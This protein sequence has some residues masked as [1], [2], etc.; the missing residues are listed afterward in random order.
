MSIPYQPAALRTPAA[1]PRSP[2]SPPAQPRA[3]LQRASHLGLGA[4]A[5]GEF[6]QRMFAAINGMM[7]DMLAAVARKDL[8]DRRRRQAQG[9]S[10]LKLLGAI[11]AGPRTQVVIRG[12]GICSPT[13]L[14]GQRFSMPPDGRA[15]PSPKSPAAPEH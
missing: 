13:L 10:M 6:T 15:P 4:S 3:T 12:S 14:R 5:S 7:L 2:G 8:D 1:R 9:I 11:A